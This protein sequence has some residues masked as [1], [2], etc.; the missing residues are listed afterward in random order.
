MSIKCLCDKYHN[1]RFTGHSKVRAKTTGTRILAPKICGKSKIKT[2][3][4]IRLG[5][6]ARICGSS[7]V[8]AFAN[9]DM[10]PSK[11][12]CEESAKIN[13]NAVVPILHIR[14]KLRS[15]SKFKNN[16]VDKFAGSF[17][18]MKKINNFLAQ[19]K[20][21]PSGDI[22]SQGFV[23]ENVQGSNLFSSIDEGVFTGSYIERSSLTTRIDNNNNYI[24]P[25]SVA[26]EGAFSYKCDVNS[27][28]IKTK[29]SF[30]FMR[31]AVPM[32][33]YGS[34][35]SPQIN[36]TN[37]K[38]EDPNG[39]LMVKYKDL[40]FRGDAEY[41]SPVYGNNY[42]TYITEPEINYGGRHEWEDDFPLY[43]NQT[44]YSLSFDVEVLC[45]DD[46]FDEGFNV[47][48]EEFVCETVGI[49]SVSEDDDYLSLDGAPLSTQT[50]GVFSPT[51]NLRISAIEI[52]NS[53][54]PRKPLGFAS[55]VE[56]F[57]NLSTEVQ[58]EGQ[59]IIKHIFPTEVMP[60]NFETTIYPSVETIWR[61]DNTMPGLE[62]SVYNLTDN[63]ASGEFL[64]DQISDR[65]LSTWIELHDSSIQ[66][67]GKLIVKFEDSSQKATSFFRGRDFI[68]GPFSPAFDYSR[69]IST[70][71]DDAFY[72][73]I[74]KVDLVVNAR[75]A[76]G[77][78][79]F[80][81]DVVGY[82]DDKIIF[83]TDKQG[84]F[85]QNVEGGLVVD[86][87]VIS[88]D[89]I[90]PDD[91]GISSEAISDKTE[92]ITYSN[93]IVNEGGDHYVLT[94]SP[95][96]NDFLF[97]EYKIPLK[98]YDKQNELGPDDKFDSST[99][100]ENLYLD[101]YPIPSGA[102]IADI[103]LEVQY[104]PQN[105]IHL[106]TIGVEAGKQFFYSNM[107][108]KIVPFTEDST[109]I[110]NYDIDNSTLPHAYSLA[111]ENN[112]LIPQNLSRRWRGI[113]GNTF[114]HA[115]NISFDFSFYKEFDE[116]PFSSGY[117]NFI[118]YNNDAVFDSEGKSLSGVF[119]GLS[120]N[121]VY[122][123]LGW[124]FNS[125][126]IYDNQ[127]AN[128]RTINWYNPSIHPQQ[129]K[130]KDA[131]DSAIRVSGVSK[132]I[133]FDD[134]N[135]NDFSV[136]V[137]FSPDEILNATNNVFEDSVIVSKY[138][139]GNDLEFAIGYSDG[140][141]C[142]YASD[143]LG[144]VI[145][146]SDSEDA[147]VN[148]TATSFPLSALLT[149]D[150]D[151]NKLR[152]YSDH[153]HHMW[154]HIGIPRVGNLRAVS[155]SFEKVNTNQDITVG[156]S[157]G[158]GVGFTGFI[159]EL[160]FSDYAIKE[161][162]LIINNKTYGGVEDFFASTRQNDYRS[163]RDKLW[164]YL[165]SDISANWHLGEFRN[166]N[167]NHEF[168]RL[169]YRGDKDFIQHHLI[170]DG[171]PYSSRT[172][173]SMPSS[174][175]ASGLAYHTQIEN[176]FLRFNI[177]DVPEDSGK[178]YAAAV[179]ISKNLPRG[180][181][182][183]EEAITVDTVVEYVT[184]DA[185]SWDDGK[186]GPKLIVSL[187]SPS[188]VPQ[189]EGADQSLGLINRHI[190]NLKP[191][192]CIQKISST[193]DHDNLLDESEPW[194]LFNRNKEHIIKEFNH[195]Y[196]STNI[197][198]M[199]LQYDLAYPSGDSFD[200]TIRLHAAQVRLKNC[201]RE[202]PSVKDN[203]NLSVSGNFNTQEKLNL[204]HTGY[205]IAVS[206]VPSGLSC[207]IDGVV[208]PEESS[209]ANLFASGG[210]WIN[211]EL[212][213]ETAG[214]SSLDIFSQNFG[215]LPDDLQFGSDQP[216][217]F[218][219]NVEGGGPVGLFNLTVYNEE[220]LDTPSGTLNLTA[221]SSRKVLKDINS[222]LNFIVDTTE[223]L[224]FGRVAQGSMNLTSFKT[225]IFLATSSPLN[226]TNYYEL[227][228]PNSEQSRLN[229]YTI[230]YPAFDANL[231]QQQVMQWNGDNIGS[232]VFVTDNEYL[233]VDPDD[234]IRGVITTC[235]GNC[236]VTSLCTHPD[237]VTH[238]INWR[239]DDCHEGGVIRALDV[240]TNLD[241][242]YDKNYYGARKYTGLLPHYPYV[243]N[244]RGFTGST[245][246]VDLPR[247]M[248]TVE[249]GSNDNVNFSGIKIF[250]NDPFAL[251]AKYGKSVATK[252]DLLVIGAP[253]YVLYDDDKE[254]DKSGAVFVY[255]RDLA[256]SGFDW[257]DQYDKASWNLEEILT[258]PSG[259]YRDYYNTSL[260][261]IEGGGQQE[262]FVRRWDIG[263]W[264]RNF[265]HSVDVAIDEKTG[266][267]IVVVG[268]PKAKFEREFTETVSTTLKVCVMVIT[269]EFDGTAARF[270]KSMFNSI[271]NKNQYFSMF[272]Y[273]AFN[274]DVDV[275]LLEP[276]KNIP[277]H[278]FV[279]DESLLTNF[280]RLQI[281]RK[282]RGEDSTE[283][284]ARSVQEIADAFNSVY[285]INNSV[286]NN[287][288]PVVIGMVVDESASCGRD[289]VPGVD[290]FLDYYKN[291]AFQNGLLTWDGFPTS[292]IVEE[293]K[294][295]FRD[296]E[297]WQ[298]LTFRNIENT[299]SNENIADNLQVYA[300]GFGILFS[301]SDTKF[302]LLP[303]SGGR[304]YVFENQQYASGLFYN[305]SGSGWYITQQM[306]LD[307]N[308]YNQFKPNE[309]FGFSVSI[310]DNLENVAVGSP[311]SDT[312]GATVYELSTFRD[313]HV[314]YLIDWIVTR[315]E[316]EARE[317][318]DPIIYR[319]LYREYEN[320]ISQGFGTL[321]AMQKVYDLLS[322]SY[323]FDLL[324][325]ASNSYRPKSG[326]PL[327]EKYR[328]TFDYKND[329]NY[330]GTY[331][332]YPQNYAAHPRVGYSID[333]NEDGTLLA[334]GCPTDSMNEWDDANVWYRNRKEC[335]E[336][337]FGGYVS[338]YDSE[339]YLRTNK[340]TSG[341]HEGTWSS[342]VNAGAVQVFSGRRYYPHNK[343]VEY[344]IFG[345]ANELI[346][347]PESVR[348]NTRLSEFNIISGVCTQRREPIEFVKTDFIDPNIP[349]DAGLLFILSPAKD[350]LSEEVLS[351]IREWLA[352]GDRNLVIVGDDPIFEEN[353]YYEETNRVANKILEAV[354][355]RVRLYP[356][357][358]IEHAQ[359]NPTLDKNVIRAREPEH[360]ISHNMI[361]N[362]DI[363]L[364]ASGVSDIRLYDPTMG[365][366][367]HSCDG[368]ETDDTLAL[369]QTFLGADQLE[370]LRESGPLNRYTYDTANIGCEQPIKHEG[371]LR[372][373]WYEWCNPFAQNNECSPE[374]I[375]VARNIPI[376]Y[377]KSPG[378]TDPMCHKGI[379][380]T[381]TPNGSRFAS[382]CFDTK[383]CEWT[384][385][386]VDYPPVPL[387]SIAEESPSF[388][389]IR[390]GIPESSFT[391]E[392]VVGREIDPD[393]NKRLK[394]LGTPRLSNPIMNWDAIVIPNEET[395]VLDVEYSG[396]YKEVEINVG[397]DLWNAGDQLF[398]PE[399]TDKA[400][401]LQG[402]NSRTTEDVREDVFASQYTNIVA[403]ESFSEE[404]TSSVI[405]ISCVSTESQDVL[406]NSL[407]GDQF[408]YFYR[409][410]LTKRGQDFEDFDSAGNLKLQKVNVAQLGGWT[411]RSSFK[412]GYKDSFIYDGE[413]NS[414]IEFNINFNQVKNIKLNVDSEDLL[415]PLSNDLLTSGSF[416]ICWIANTKHLPSEEDMAKLKA[417]LK[418]GNKKLIITYAHDPEA[419]NIKL[420]KPSAEVA[421]A[422]SQ[423]CEQLGLSMKPL[424]LSGENRFA[425]LGRDQFTPESA[426][427]FNKPNY[428]FVQDHYLSYSFVNSRTTLRL[429][430]F[431]LST[432]LP[433]VFSDP[434]NAWKRDE[435]FLIPID[436]Q[437]A[438]RVV[439]LVGKFNRSLP[440]LRN[441]VRD[442][443]GSTLNYHYNN[444]G[445]SK[446]SFDVPTMN[447]G[448]FFKIGLSV[449]S[450]SEDKSTLKCRVL[451]LNTT[452]LGQVDALGRPILPS[453]VTDAG[454]GFLDGPKVNVL[455][456]IGQKQSTLVP[457]TTV[458]EI[459]P[460][461]PHGDSIDLY[462]TFNDL[463]LRSLSAD[464]GLP[465]TAKV[466]FVSGYPVPISETR[467]FIDII[468]LEEVIVPAI[469]DVEI[470]FQPPLRE[471]GS[472]H[473]RYCPDQTEDGCL[474]D[475]DKP[476]QQR[477]GPAMQGWEAEYLHG[478]NIKTIDGPVVVSQ[479][480]E[481]FS[482]FIA[483]FARSRI[484]V[485]SDAS[486]IQGSGA[487]NPD[488]TRPTGLSRLISF[489]YPDTSFEDVSSGKNYT[490]RNK[491]VSPERGSPHKWYSAAGHNDLISRFNPNNNSIPILP[492]SSFIGHESAYDPLYVAR[493]SWPWECEDSPPI[494]DTE[495]VKRAMLASFGSSLEGGLSTKFSGVIDGQAYGDGI[496]L[497]RDK[498]YDFL[499]FEHFPEGY[500]GDLF[501]YSV[502][503]R[504]NQL[505]VGA[506]FSA[507]S[508][509]SGIV[510]WSEISTTQL[511]EIPSGVQLSKFGG[512][513]SV[514]MFEN[515][516][517]GISPIRGQDAAWAYV[518]KFRPD[519]IN[520]GQDYTSSVESN[521][522][523]E[524]GNNG[525]SF[526]DLALDSRFTD[527][528]GHDL[529]INEGVLAIGAP[530]HDFENFVDDGQANGLFMNKAFGNAFTN[531]DRVVYDLGTSGVRSD[532]PNS[533][534]AVL[535]N[536]AVY[537]YSEDYNFTTRDNYWRMVEK[538]V[539]QGVNS[540]KQ[541]A[542]DGS[543]PVAISGS[544]N[545][546]FGESV[547]VSKNNRTDSDYTV[548]VG[549]K[550]H[551]F[552]DT[553]IEPCYYNEAIGSFSISAADTN[554]VMI[555]CP[556]TGAV[557]K[558]Y[559]QGLHNNWYLG[560]YTNNTGHL[561]IYDGVQTGTFNVGDLV[562]FTIGSSSIINPNALYEVK[563]IISHSNFDSATN[564]GPSQVL[565]VGCPSPALQAYS[566]NRGA[567]YTYDL[568]LRRPQPAFRSNDA[569]ILGR[570][571]G[572]SGII[573]GDTERKN[574]ITFSI[575]NN[576]ENREQH[577]E[578]GIIYTNRY[579]EI[580]IEASGQDPS[581]YGLTQ[582]RP[583]I[584]GVDG[585]ILNGE[586]KTNALRLNTEGRPN[587]SSG[588][589]NLSVLA[590]D[591]A[592]VYNNVGLYNFGVDG[593]VQ[594]SGLYLTNLASS[595]PVQ[596]S[597]SLL[598]F[599]SG[600]GSIN[601]DINLRVRGF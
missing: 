532:L 427:K 472:S 246:L 517:K 177:D 441:G 407:S 198:D 419:E 262:F 299:L 342:Y 504:K 23:N 150:S 505:F 136:F 365:T 380:I 459:G 147:V 508:Q 521:S 166:C 443:V 294:V 507:Y 141:L 584:F 61:S 95:L 274:V 363:K 479:E 120:T 543:I 209:Q 242:G 447:S 601:S 132:H 29:H 239:V 221:F 371:D 378:L 40:L 103:R 386:N 82:S 145:K 181:N 417:W 569:N 59:K 86:A 545:S 557:K 401:I 123:N 477:G 269:D 408:I 597:G 350:A 588:V 527:R 389:Y 234:E 65:G 133:T 395:G 528:F 71:I 201:L 426:T 358:N 279:D 203:L 94:Q 375:R 283:A 110:F 337:K 494:K 187:Y 313:L 394:V 164:D 62:G 473:Y 106:H 589:M 541:K 359:V 316:T 483:G 73:N 189:Y 348:T 341:G 137:R 217:G 3:V 338:P 118:N 44:G 403:E 411:K 131:F 387:F 366:Y 558:R 12:P 487:L 490:L 321:G 396:N 540:H 328:Q 538:V 114:N 109:S 273:P 458:V 300:S 345:N 9:S 277:N 153:E 146:I 326:K 89:V 134:I 520:V 516:N 212:R 289:L 320:F 381:K 45:L 373:Q 353:G 257:S 388:T 232:Q 243:V 155:D 237:I 175:N 28:L 183:E 578:S 108:L 302:N 49:G 425:E 563:D 331:A 282:L 560:L 184:D 160:G 499:D 35:T 214:H 259:Y 111:D 576:E 446:V 429:G 503:L 154:G 144:N 156:Y 531:P 298:S 360:S 519:S 404:L 33:N 265:G 310:S 573:F 498:G 398:I 60:H 34:N 595:A 582:H 424:F 587:E 480:I 370:A 2:D 367:H 436:L 253:E 475:F 80:A 518:R 271:A 550:N 218:F 336:E 96:I 186:I 599:A 361:F 291:Y 24:Q 450:P 122:R 420:R 492:M 556:S 524:L 415:N 312:T 509:E 423:I 568:M 260:G 405:L 357:Q 406:Q 440:W 591:K 188:L 281:S 549:S 258:L 248:N 130:I 224:D 515:N 304:A 334:I 98:I 542:Y 100:F 50:Q 437:G 305:D 220:V 315:S 5:A 255:R 56:H 598:L 383:S 572:S 247:E 418:Q 339:A 87:N 66:D 254:L 385:T 267:E 276:T 245:D 22:Q 115:Y 240:Y 4:G 308:E 173:I 280:H 272:S 194:A 11:Y 297:D 215:S 119:T 67:S 397:D 91:L 68:G 577:V 158:S 491:I 364:F 90:Q 485:I 293:V 129:Y 344:G 534:T 268:A 567:A 116:I 36:I 535:N 251:H 501:G 127:A 529:D 38:L 470:V 462:M 112:N 372:A 355:S 252:G 126:K 6:S 333:L 322:H 288:L 26:T 210:L 284:S 593:I 157:S 413:F 489:L 523:E 484:T 303:P 219:L 586:I 496:S 64:G 199:F 235:H 41:L 78:R 197:N 296:S 231:T 455:D 562:K 374:S 548:I 14:S 185:I 343:A 21:Y 581:E 452:Y 554:R 92:T 99:F 422:T 241:V 52:C 191:S 178:F 39:D 488:G 390:P 168:N 514:Y 402:R 77:S 481:I 1:L 379:G 83:V 172:D 537:L 307:L 439:S 121:D 546:H 444:S 306:G 579:G 431:P 238:G 148:A 216:R 551:P 474:D 102:D 165:D 17:L 318:R 229:L 513:G 79:D 180:Y 377:G 249:Y 31:A 478:E 97:K 69:S 55:F 600:I 72:S 325:F 410:L 135:S 128:H 391:R 435:S 207:F 468:E 393:P 208:W 278:E 368:S 15:E 317:G 536:G 354:D 16:Y 493:P 101:I 442:T 81:L 352:Y 574:E 84:G 244:V 223:T 32:K 327:P 76:P 460:Y 438:T 432:D 174:L 466:S 476:Q 264:G 323:R 594:N 140:V 205:H 142:G 46:P 13:A 171:L 314:E 74:Y 347:S 559:I 469:P 471:M 190:H 399:P 465:Y 151:D 286:R 449:Q 213:L 461:F 409:N 179:R 105:A 204:N 206:S 54:D 51:D 63:R 522:P 263:N 340:I 37:I 596:N 544:E 113:S 222:S 467:P 202:L 211:D 53:G 392:I 346:T 107:P 561:V 85:L 270:S 43:S 525:Y 58:L 583:F 555:E 104:A 571:F 421:Y 453:K 362:D 138:N 428:D 412:D 143:N 456:D 93:T 486:M 18:S 228:P 590:E 464:Q 261:Q 526:T 570:V 301:T 463:R 7:K 482:P 512:A 47:G 124:R 400:F 497:Y 329:Y 564:Y 19:Q 159:T 356:A 195:K 369:A 414:L 152:L 384:A 57:M 170:H 117:Y 533:G 552:D 335:P 167:F 161:S 285:P 451:N 430:E 225:D 192:G 502:A 330:Q 149:Y 233:S 580:F 30:L 42:A 511:N 75:K 454:Q 236:G 162:N 196:Y 266:N 433:S 25:S 295:D 182:F 275:I 530:G 500:P 510:N 163:N 553:N 539:P 506:P 349:Q 70:P 290:N 575:T 416:D 566:E 547:A 250:S 88:S 445:F 565:V 125:D 27:A 200:S 230:N 139:T 226:L 169:S 10:V 332:M 434:S 376:A 292:G 382:C 585:V 457:R 48:Y 324:I 287:N 311:F 319:Q 256:P 309:G 193:F 227:I 592:N 448:Y 495:A 20:L 351:N 8:K 176:D